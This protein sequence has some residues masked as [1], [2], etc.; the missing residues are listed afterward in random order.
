MA[1]RL[2][3]SG[4]EVL[5]TNP[6]V[7]ELLVGY[8]DLASYS[9]CLAKHSTTRRLLQSSRVKIAPTIIFGFGFSK[10][11]QIR[12]LGAKYW[13]VGHDVSA[14]QLLML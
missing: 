13:R 9:Y 4:L 8:D 6:V 2:K 1:P 3:V 11:H 10:F 7:K 12:N 5:S 14:R